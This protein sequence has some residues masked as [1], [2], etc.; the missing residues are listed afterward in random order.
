[1]MPDSPSSLVLFAF[2]SLRLADNPALPASH[3]TRRT[4]NTRVRMDAH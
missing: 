1:M 3:R 2:G 4:G